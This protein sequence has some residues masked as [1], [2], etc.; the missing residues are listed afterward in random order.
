[1]SLLKLKQ[2]DLKQPDNNMDLIDEPLP[3]VKIFRPFVF[4]DERGSFVKP[5]HEGQLG[6]YGISMNV[7]EEFFSTS[8]AEVIRGMHFQM[9]PHAHQKI[10]YCLTGRILDVV[11]DLRE[12]S[13]TFGESVA[14]ELSAR[15]RHIVPIPVGFAHGFLSHEDDSCLIYKTDAVHSPD[16]DAGILWNSFGFNWPIKNFE[17]ISI[18][19]R[20]QKHSCF[21]KFKTPF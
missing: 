15:N 10:V 16:C 3:G 5:F 11:L 19:D 13:P 14:F 8:A 4:E 7:K 21:E 1:M 17:D 6:D 12:S 2:T 20:D 18:S 9:P